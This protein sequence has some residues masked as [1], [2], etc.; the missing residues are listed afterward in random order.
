MRSLLAALCALCLL[1]ACSHAQAISD[2][3]VNQL[4][5]ADLQPIRQDEAQLAQTRGE[6]TRQEDTINDAETELSEAQKEVKQSEAEI[7]AKKLQL[8]QAKAHVEAAQARLAF[9]HAE[10]KVQQA[11]LV[12]QRAQIQQ[13]KYHALARAQDPSVKSMEA[14]SFDAKV[15][16]TKAELTDAQQS[17]RKAKQ[18]YEELRKEWRTAP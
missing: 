8:D 12:F 5:Q 11:K 18:D 10:L 13:A 16:D 14:A 7:E 9:A 1:T 3:R 15:Q 17:A 4:S 2:E 6:E